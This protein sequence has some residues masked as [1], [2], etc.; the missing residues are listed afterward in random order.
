LQ[1]LIENAV[2]YAVANSDGPARISISAELVGGDVM[3]A[4]TDSGSGASAPQP[5]CGIGLLNV[6]SRL[7]AR[8]GFRQQLNAGPAD[9][10]GF[11]VTIRIPSEQVTG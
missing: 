7:H 10:G 9:G 3:I 6:R 5:G 8:Y 1:P 2:K 4:V 11:R